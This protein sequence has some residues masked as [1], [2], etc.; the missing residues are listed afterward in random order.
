MTSRDEEIITLL[1]NSLPD[2]PLAMVDMDRAFNEFGLDSL[3]AMSVLLAIETKFGLKIPDA[4]VD[5]LD[6]PNKVLAYVNQRMDSK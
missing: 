1:G 5:K 3:D 2:G 6:T 4:D